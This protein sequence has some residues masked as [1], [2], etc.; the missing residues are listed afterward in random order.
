[1]IYTQPRHSVARVFAIAKTVSTE[2]AIRE[3]CALCFAE[4]QDDN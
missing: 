4:L 3:S 2:S 1:M